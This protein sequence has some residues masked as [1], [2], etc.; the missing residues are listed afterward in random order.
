M[1]AVPSCVVQKTAGFTAAADLVSHWLETAGT[2]KVRNHT[3]ICTPK[4][5]RILMGMFYFC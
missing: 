2:V 4:D 5:L 3:N 1:E